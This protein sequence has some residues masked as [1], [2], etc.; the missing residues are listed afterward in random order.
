MSRPGPEFPCVRPEGLRDRWRYWRAGVDRTKSMTA[1]GVIANTPIC[2]FV[3]GNGGGKTLAAVYAVLPTLRG[4][5]WTCENPDHLHTHSASCTSRVMLS[6]E[7]TAVCDCETEWENTD[8]G[9]RVTVL[10]EGG[11]TTGMRRVLSTVELRDVTAP[12]FSLRNP[13]PY[14]DRLRSFVQLLGVE[15]TDVLMDEV[16]GVASSRSS[17]SLPVQVENLVQQLRRRD[18]R[19]LWTTPDYGNADLRIRSVT[20]GVVLCR[21]RFAVERRGVWAQARLFRWTMFDASEFDRFTVGKRE[22]LVP[23]ARQSFWRPGHIAERAYDTA[24]AVT[25]LGAA[26]EGGMCFS[27]GGRRS[28]PACTCPS[29]P[30]RLPPGVVEIVTPSGSR[31]RLVDA[32]AAGGAA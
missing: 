16:T 18:A 32:A 8:D 14:Y 4:S 17:M 21:G 3:G 11:T 5:R 1:A 13:S 15:H 9:R 10:A 31:K 29:D 20:R 6:T 2:A 7:P 28:A 19:L 26:A 25:Q 23:V 27:C 12:P 30:D 22:R 24:A